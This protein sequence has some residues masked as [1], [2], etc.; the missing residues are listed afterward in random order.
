MFNIVCGNV[1]LY[2][3]NAYKRKFFRIGNSL[4]FC[5][6]YKQRAYKPRTI[7]NANSVQVVQ[8]YPRFL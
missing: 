2:M 3:V 6:P 8:R 5:N 4:G 1:P 7:G